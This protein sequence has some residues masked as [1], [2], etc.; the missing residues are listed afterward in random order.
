MLCCRQLGPY[1][2]LPRDSGCRDLRLYAPSVLRNRDPI[3]S[4]LRR[5]LPT[6]G[7]VLEV[8]SGSGE[9]V[10]HLAQVCSAFRLCSASAVYCLS[11]A[12]LKV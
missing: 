8:G 3:T 1:W 4:V 6:A 9:H 5:V 12:L 10:V 11:G 2:T 7:L